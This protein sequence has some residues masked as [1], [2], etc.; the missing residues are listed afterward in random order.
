MSVTFGPCTM[1]STELARFALLYPSGVDFESLSPEQLA[2]VPWP[3][4]DPQLS[5]L[6]W[7]LGPDRQDEL[8][9]NVH[10]GGAAALMAEL[11]MTWDRCDGPSGRCDLREFVGRCAAAAY[12]V[13]LRAGVLTGT[14]LRGAP[15]RSIVLGTD[16]QYLFERMTRLSELANRMLEFGFTHISWG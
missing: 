13:N 12:H 4:Q 7:S 11:G 10:N 14:D 1:S 16:D 6:Y 2:C 15:V 5:E 9:L 8:S 3:N